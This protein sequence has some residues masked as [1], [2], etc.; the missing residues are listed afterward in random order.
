MLD[1][2]IGD[3]KRSVND[4]PDRLTRLCDGMIRSLEA[5]PE[6]RKGDRCIVFMSDSQRGGMVIHGYDE[7]DDSDAEAM[8]DLVVH[9]KALFKAHDKRFQIM[10]VGDD[11]VTTI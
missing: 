10:L 6:H 2:G 8:T 4:P 1:D 3:I 5:H 11:G 9:L 7:S